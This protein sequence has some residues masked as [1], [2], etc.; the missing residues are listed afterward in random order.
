MSDKTEDLPVSLSERQAAGKP[1]VLI[2]DD[3][4]QYAHLFEL[5][6]DR[7]GITAYIVD[8]C[9]AGIQSLEKFSFDVILMDWVMPEVDGPMCTANIRAL[10]KTTGAHIPII[11]V[12]GHIRATHEHCIA[13]GMDDF[14][15]VPFTL[16]LLQEKLCYW[17]KEKKSQ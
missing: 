14:L 7:L 1:L 5:L 9:G 2:I 10:E 15:P 6:S 8:S 4:P 11:G 17:L 16:E 12:S 13:A 3:N